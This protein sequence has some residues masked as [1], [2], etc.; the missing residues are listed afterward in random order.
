ML[1]SENG[2]RRMWNRARNIVIG[3]KGKTA[4][5][6]GDMKVRWKDEVEGDA[7]KRASE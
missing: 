1:R 4:T 3:A 2:E 5:Y 7:N 6:E